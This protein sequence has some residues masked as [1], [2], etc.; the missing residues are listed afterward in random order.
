MTRQARAASAYDVTLKTLG[1][2]AFAGVLATALHDASLAWDSPYYHLPFA[3]RLVGLLP[4][5]SFTFH[6]AN[7]ARYEG[8]AL[9]AE[10]VQGLLWRLTGRAESA[11]LVACS[12]VPLVAWFLAR[13]WKVPL[14]VTML[15]LF[16]IPLVQTHA[17][18]AY[19]DLPGNAAAS[20]LVLLVIEAWA[21]EAPLPASDVLLALLMGAVAANI[22]PLLQPVVGLG[23]LAILARSVRD[24]RGSPARDRSLR[25]VLGMLLAAPLVLFT[26]LKNALAHRNPFYPIGTRLLGVSL[27]GPEGPY[28]SSPLWLEHAPRPARFLASILEV[29]VRP[30]DDPHRWTVDQWAPYD[31]DA[32]R[33]GGF[34]GAYVALSLLVFVHRVARGRSRLERVSGVVFALFTALIACMPQSHELRYYLSWMIVLVGLN[35]GLA[36]RAAPLRYAPGLRALGALA[37]LSFGVVALSTRGAYLRAGGLG[38]SELVA[39]RVDPRLLERVRDGEAICVRREPFNLLW[40]DLFHAPRH[41]RVQEAEEPADCGGVRPVEGE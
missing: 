24:L 39:A 41:Y 4:P 30:L 31:S 18:S 23:L 29:G 25:V 17:P 9:L 14:P 5:S 36:C 35:L 2:L 15:A 21:F 28:A 6:P 3:A 32:L 12:S 13:R 8:F 26:P 27:P 34:F 33:M 7:Q 37:A 19:V 22:K 38:M 20:V 11:N 10:L 1:W 40:A 16:A